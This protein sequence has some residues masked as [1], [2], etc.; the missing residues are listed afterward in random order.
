MDGEE[1]DKIKEMVEEMVK[2]V[3]KEEQIQENVHEKFPPSPFNKCCPEKGPQIVLADDADSV[4]NALTL[5]LSLSTG[6]LWTE[7]EVQDCLKG[8]GMNITE[9]F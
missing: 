2:E 8:M 9:D 1:S 7:V 4:I 5:C 6:I 3:D